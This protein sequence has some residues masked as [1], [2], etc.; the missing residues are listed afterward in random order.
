MAPYI[1]KLGNK[2]ELD[3]SIKNR[4][5]LLV[6]IDFAGI[7]V[8]V[9]LQRALRKKDTQVETL[10]I[11]SKKGEFDEEKFRDIVEKAKQEKRAVVF[12]D[13]RTKTGSLGRILE[14]R[15]PRDILWRYAVLYDPLKGQRTKAGRGADIR[16]SARE[17]P[18]F[19]QMVLEPRTKAI[20]EKE[21]ERALKHKA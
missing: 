6:G 11:S 15:M 19:G 2:I 17:G 5:L 13:W 20:I 16:T 8:S 10:R 18:W 1:V 14:E 3:K 4:R 12:V 7:P 21:V 9:G